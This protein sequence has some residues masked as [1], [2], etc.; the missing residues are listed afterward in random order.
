SYKR[1]LKP[2]IETEVRLLTKKNADEDAI[3]VFSDNAKQ[4]LMSAPLG[5]KRVL[6]ID[7]GFR[8]GCKVVCLDEQGKLLYNTNIYPHTGAKGLEDAKRTISQLADQF[9]IDT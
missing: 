2:S 9:L 5:Q 7:P 4:L 1:L 8:T 6:S 3:R